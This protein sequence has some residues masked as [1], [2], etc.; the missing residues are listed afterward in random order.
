MCCV[1][2]LSYHFEFQV[3]ERHISELQ[4]SEPTNCR[5]FKIIPELYSNPENV[6][7]FFAT[8]FPR[9]AFTQLN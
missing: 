9:R 3:S 1:K 6:H 8:F 2:G 7:S 4:F 5:T